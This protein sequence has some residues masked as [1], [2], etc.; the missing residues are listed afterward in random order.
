MSKK[1]E[2]AKTDDAVIKSLE[3]RKEY[4]IL[5]ESGALPANI[6]TVEK[7]MAI[8]QMGKELGLPAMVAINNI[9]MIQGRT[10]ISS[11]MLGAMLK[12]RN[13]EWTWLK[14]H[15]VEE[16]GDD[17]RIVTE[18]EF[19]WISKV[20]KRPKSTTF[21][22]TWAQMEVAGY[23]SKQNWQKY[24]KEMMRARCLA[25]AVRAIFPEV[26]MGMYTDL[27]ILDAN[28]VKADVKLSPEGDVIVDD[29]EII[30]D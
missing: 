20:T 14:D 9:N 22:I 1:E 13:I 10:V 17:I 11:T 7:A 4:E 29:V 26:L 6:D 2:L 18:L 25:Y 5:I 16:N 15:A 28:D 3:T 23:T 24:P 19:E 30:E 12:N 21:S 27:E 8:I